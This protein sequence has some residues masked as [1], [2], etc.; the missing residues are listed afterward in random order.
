MGVT[1]TVPILVRAAVNQKRSYVSYHQSRQLPRLPADNARV[2][3]VSGGANSTLRSPLVG[4]F[5]FIRP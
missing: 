2:A 3:S 1:A 5:G 4:V